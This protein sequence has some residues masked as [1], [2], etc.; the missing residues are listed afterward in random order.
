VKSL[1][2]SSIQAQ[3]LQVNYDT[4]WR[5]PRKRKLVFAK[6]EGIRECVQEAVSVEA[7]AIPRVSR[8]GNTQRESDLRLNE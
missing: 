2:I 6:A 1:S 8:E 3:Y 5:Q 4:A 7:L